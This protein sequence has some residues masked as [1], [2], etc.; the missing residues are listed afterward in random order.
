M[1]HK[2]QAVPIRV[3]EINA[4][5][6][7]RTATDLYPVLFQF[8]FECFVRAALNIEGFHRAIAARI[9]RQ[10]LVEQQPRAKVVLEEL[11]ARGGLARR[12]PAGTGRNPSSGPRG[13]PTGGAKGS[14]GPA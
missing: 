11:A 5:R 7:P 9:E 12:R 13:E 14:A 1:H 6:I 2:L 4:V 10:A 3:M 8:G